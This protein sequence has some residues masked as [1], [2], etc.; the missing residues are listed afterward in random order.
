MHLYNSDILNYVENTELCF[1]YSQTCLAGHL[2]GTDCWAEH[3][4][5]K[6]DEGAFA[7]VMNARYGYGAWESTDGPSQRFNRE[8]WDAVFSE[9]EGYPEIGKAN[10]DSKEDNIYRINESCMRWCCYELNLFGDPTVAFMGAMPALTVR[11]PEECPEFIDPG[12]PTTIPVEIISRAEQYVEGSG[13][14]YYRFDGGTYE[15]SPLVH[16]EGDLYEATLP[17]AACDDVPEYYFSAEGDG[18]TV[19]CSPFNAPESVY[20]CR[21]GHLV[22][23][24][25]D[26]FETDQ[27]WT[28]YAGAD[29]GNWERADPQEVSSSGTV[30]QPGDDHSADGTLCFVT[31]PLAGGGAG[32]Y[33][34]D[35]GPTHLTSPRL[36]LAGY[37][38]EI[39]YWRWYHISTQLDDELL[40]Q[41]SNDD[42]ANWTTVES[43]TNRQTWTLAQWRVGDFVT[44]TDEVRVRFTAD[45]SPNN[46]L[47]EALIDDFAISILECGESE[48]PEDLNGDGV[49]NTEDLLTLLANWGTSGDGDIDGNGVVGTSD[50]L[51]LL[52]AWGDCP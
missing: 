50:L 39:S 22:Q 52:A 27:G 15:T 23:L 16:V 5:I 24:M 9:S 20:T 3:M 47:V 4:N 2:D 13:M 36:E 6:I 19:V 26:D 35:G 21:V 38:A 17:G 51:M 29:T 25:A 10:Q 34:V 14:L 48:C 33:D 49:V 32:D 12:V 41:V 45:D 28:V 43:I 7:V 18:G 44:P 40:V 8:L 30:T 42:G 1:V 11:L 31:G 46:S 37:D